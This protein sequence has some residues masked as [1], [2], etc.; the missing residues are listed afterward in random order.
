MTA[1]G[2]EES[3]LLESH[4]IAGVVD[5]IADQRGAVPRINVAVGVVLTWTTAT[6]R[7]TVQIRGGVFTDLPAMDTS[8]L[9]SMVA[10][11]NVLVLM[12]NNQW[13]IQGRILD[14]I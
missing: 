4:Q 5:T 6:R 8:A 13:L 11:N 12:V 10:G 2:I 7:N 3:F 9:A 1:F 14:P